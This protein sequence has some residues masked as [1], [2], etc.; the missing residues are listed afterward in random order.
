MHFA[1][2]KRDVGGEEAFLGPSYGLLPGRILPPDPGVARFARA[3][4]CTSC[5]DVTA[6]SK[7]TVRYGPMN[8]L[9]LRARFALQGPLYLLQEGY[10]DIMGLTLL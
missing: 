6:N 4:V 1:M 2:T 8:M 7:R 9:F 5:C 3:F 10:I